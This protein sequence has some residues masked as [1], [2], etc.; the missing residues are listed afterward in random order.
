MSLFPLVV[1]PRISILFLPPLLLSALPAMLSPLLLLFF[2]FQMTEIKTVHVKC[3]ICGDT[4]H[5]TRDCAMRRKPEGEQMGG[6]NKEVLDAEYLN[7]MMELGEVSKV[8][9]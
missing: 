6:Q 2:L 3:A 5:P 4:S 8:E 7:F 1:R 9:G